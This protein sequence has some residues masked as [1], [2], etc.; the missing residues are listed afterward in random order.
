MIVGNSEVHD[1]AANVGNIVL[2]V[3]EDKEISIFFDNPYATNK[4]IEFESSNPDV[5]ECL[6][7][8]TGDC[9]TGIVRAYSKG[10]TTILAR[11]G[12]LSTVVDV[13]VN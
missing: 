9:V 2:M 1:I 3:G 8:N 6:L 12:N 10:H 5:A 7:S 4:D 11:H 13:E